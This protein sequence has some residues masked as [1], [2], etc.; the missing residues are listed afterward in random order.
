MFLACLAVVGQVNQVWWSKGRVLH[1]NPVAG[2]DSVT[3]GQF[4]NAD[5]FL[6]VI[7]RASRR[8]V[9]DT[10]DE[11]VPG[12]VF[13]DTIYTTHTVYLEPGR[14][15]GVFSVAKDRQVSFSQGNLQYVRNQDV[16]KFADQQYEYIGARNV[17]DGQLA[18]KIDL[19]GWSADNT[20]APFGVSTSTNNADY[21]GEFVDWGV[22]EINIDAPNTW[23]TL[24]KDEWEYLINKRDNASQLYGAACV[25]GINGVMFMPD[26][27]VCPDGVIFVSGMATKKGSEYYQTQNNYSLDQWAVLENSGAVFL[28]A[29]GRR[30][31]D[32]V[33]INEYGNYWSNSIK[34]DHY[35][36]YLAYPSDQIYVDALQF[37]Y[38]GRS[39]R[40]VHDTIVPPPVPC[41]TFDV[42]GVEFNMMC[43]EGG[44]FTMGAGSDAHQVTLSDYYMAQ[45]ELTQVQWEAVMGKIEKGKYAI[46]K[47]GDN[48][49][50]SGI[51]LMQCQEF[52]DRLNELTGLHFRIST[53]AEW[54]YAA[55][56]G[57][58][59]KGY[60]YAGSDD[61]N[62]VAI[63]NGTVRLDENGKNIYAPE[64]VMTRKPNELGIYDMSG[65]VA[66]WVNDWNGEF[67]LYPQINPTGPTTYTTTYSHRVHYR[68]G[69]WTFPEY[70]CEVT[71]KQPKNVPSI[72]DPNR[73]FNGIGLR[74]VLS[75]EEPFKMVY[76]NDSTRI[77]LRPVKG[78]KYNCYIGETEVTY[79]LWNVVMGTVLGVEETDNKP[80][81]RVS[82]D[83]CQKFIAKLNELTGLHFRLPTEA[84]WEYAAR[85]GSRSNGYM[86]AGSNDI[87]SVGWYMINSDSTDHCVA[88]LMSNELGI[89]D[90][91]GNVWEW[92]QDYYDVNQTMHVVKSGSW[93]DAATTCRIDARTG[94]AANYKS[95]IGL[96]LV[97][98]IHQYV[99]LGLSVKWATFNLGAS[100][101][102]EYGDY[103]AWGE[104]EPKDE[105]SWENYK[106]GDGTASNMTKYN[107]KDGLTT[108]KLEDDAAHVNWGGK[109]RMPTM[110]E[111]KELYDK[112]EW[113]PETR[114]GIDGYRVVGPNGNSIFIP[115]AG[116]YNKDQFGNGLQQANVNAYYWT[117]TRT[118]NLQNEAYDLGLNTL[119]GAYGIVFNTRRLGFPIRAVYDDNVVILTI[120]CTTED[121][122]VGF[123][124]SG[125]YHVHGNSVMVKKG[126]SPLYQVAAT[127]E[128]YLSQGDTLHNITKD[129]TLNITLKPF[130]EG[131][132]VKIDNSEFTKVESYYVSKKT[133]QFVGPHSN[134]NYFYAPVVPGETYRVCAN[135]GQLAAIWYAASNA[136]NQADSIRPKKVACSENG[137]I[138]RYIAE[139]FTIPEGATYLIINH[140]GEDKNLIIERKVPD[141]CQVVRVNDTLSINMMCVEGGTFMMG[142]DS[143]DNA[144]PAHQVTLS[145]YYIGQT[146]VTQALWTA[147]MGTNPSK[148]SGNNL[149]VECV[150]WEDCQL[151]VQKLSE[152]TGLHFRLPTEAEWEFA[153]RGGVKSRGYKYVGSDDVD[154]V[155]WYGVNSE[156]KT[157]SIAGKKPNEL[158]IYDMSGN[159]WEWCQDWHE[160]YTAEAKE[161]PQGAKEGEKPVIRG[162]CWHYN[163][164]QCTPTYRYSYYDRTGSGSSTGFRIVLDIK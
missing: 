46:E 30:V 111:A 163:P 8:I 148:F 35:S 120:N 18:N 50:M 61:I 160:P 4:V 104:V 55:R 92:C 129:T 153:A 14:R 40:L 95:L 11:H 34:D 39:V 17:K 54:E 57:V 38:Y 52:V 5:T 86:F 100:A 6:I 90:M 156:Q 121:A 133:G 7:D 2:I 157:H 70:K 154:S 24:S 45:S 140:A 128:G 63:W 150:S 56:G 23:R 65:N 164:I 138:V 82:W 146:E 32:P 134:W 101:P 151:F 51:S 115:I 76:L 21:A 79:A 94:R 88:Q 59:S 137:G 162:G 131:T 84:E 145:D 43:V 85:G 81:S 44:T 19:F 42:N 159:V 48:Y 135:A 161:N 62:E 20:T 116:F 36:H 71:F 103:F 106:W 108:L 16:W 127:K 3:F 69:C 118:S 53:E 60:K 87:D 126:A 26:D 80:V 41:K 93:F 114:D 72:T 29:A 139:E 73:G 99:D 22:N 136:P 110:E 123:H 28:S 141:P 77:V 78:E 15:I 122:G 12:M 37:L 10:I 47:Y 149:P 33:N 1:V 97:L 91:T 144:S 125:G 67:N 107:E 96:R 9:Y 68:G 147:V 27:W 89:Y 102:E 155:A 74:L 117:K 142:D 113:N 105:Y 75:D 98:D 83:D 109:W 119:Q 130:S 64:P 152:M 124:Y 49:P 13:H 31:K 132:W 66:E 25:N 158:G 58:K 112:C 143:S